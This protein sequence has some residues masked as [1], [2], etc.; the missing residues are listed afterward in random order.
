MY[1]QTG[2]TAE[3]HETCQ[4]EIPEG[5]IPL[6]HD[7][8]RIRF[9]Q[10]FRRTEKYRCVSACRNIRTGIEVFLQ[11]PHVVGMQELYQ[12]FL[13]VRIQCI[14]F[15]IHMAER[16]GGTRFACTFKGDHLS[17]SV[18]EFRTSGDMDTRCPAP[19]DRPAAMAMTNR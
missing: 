3:N 9:L 10:N 16:Y 1:D 17:L 18:S 7:R 4:S 5:S 8:D 13:P 2:C 14:T 12:I 19:V 11:E 6:Y 15:P